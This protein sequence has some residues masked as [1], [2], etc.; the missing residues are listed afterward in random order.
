MKAYMSKAWDADD[1]WFADGVSQSPGGQAMALAEAQAIDRHVRADLI[2]RPIGVV[3][4]A[5]F[6]L[7]L[8]DR[9]TAFLT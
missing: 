5:D 9:L 1:L 8:A 4:H 2:E 7:A 3:G 6:Q